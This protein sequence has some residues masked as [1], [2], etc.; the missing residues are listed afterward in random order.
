MDNS[1]NSEQKPPATELTGLVRQLF[2]SLFSEKVLLLLLFMG[3][4]S[5]GITGCESTTT[6]VNGLDEREANEIMVLLANRNIKSY[7]IQEK[8]ATGGGS[9]TVLWDIAVDSSDTTLAMSILNAN[10]LPR[11]RSENL[12]ELFS[13]G[14][15]V[16]SDLQEK[17]RY[18]AGLADQIANTIRKIDG[19]VD[20]DVQ[21]S[22]PEED[23]L[24]PNAPK[25]KVTASVYVKHTGILDDP[26]S[27][28]ITK[29]RRLV[30][31]SVPGLNYDDVTVIPDRARFSE[32]PA[33][34]ETAAQP[35]NVKVWGLVVAKTS[36]FRLQMIFFSLCI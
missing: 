17:I 3:I 31:S 19:I 5:F 21:L 28:L 15:L 14:G 7:K 9:K 29:I 20:A 23:P 36:V 8:A 26:N 30:A 2:S 16:P 27:H 12:L 35:E 25:G 1:T 22:F 10:G 6:I 4:A 18:R 34:E 24:N 11:R 32:L 33:G 13:A